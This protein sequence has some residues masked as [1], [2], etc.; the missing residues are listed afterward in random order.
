MNFQLTHVFCIAL[1]PVGISTWYN[2]IGA[3]S[4][5]KNSNEPVKPLD[6]KRRRGIKDIEN[7]NEDSPL[8][9]PVVEIDEV[10]YVKDERPLF[11]SEYIYCEL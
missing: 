8:L 7:V 10:R 4:N 5:Q 1:K 9:V 3:T 2:C 6:E 11:V